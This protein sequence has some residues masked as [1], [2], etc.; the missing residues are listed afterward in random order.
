MSP[1]RPAVYAALSIL[2]RAAGPS[3]SSRFLQKISRPTRSTAHYYPTFPAALQ[4]RSRE[5][6]ITA[7]SGTRQMAEPHCS[8]LATACTRRFCTNLGLITVNKKTAPAPPTLMLGSYDYTIKLT[9]KHNL[10]CRLVACSMFP[11]PG[12]CTCN[13]G[14]P[15]D[16]AS[17]VGS[18]RRHGCFARPAEHRLHGVRIVV[19]FL[20]I[21]TSRLASVLAKFVEV[22]A[23]AGVG[24]NCTKAYGGA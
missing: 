14:Q 1:V 2:S 18:S 13:S 24:G 22:V 5:S 19:R 17:G 23:M 12:P 7:T 8:V 16:D 6:Q 20:Q 10:K 4:K 15:M 21:F 9:I 11:S 3:P